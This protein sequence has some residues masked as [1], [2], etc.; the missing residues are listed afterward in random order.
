MY[1]SVD[2]PFS[3]TI[4]V[5]KYYL[6]NISTEALEQS[7]I[8]IVWNLRVPRIILGFVV[9]GS[10]A[11]SGVAMQSITRNVMADPFI[12][13]ISSGA[14]SFVSIGFLVGGNLVNTTWFIPLLAFLGALFALIIVIIIGG[15]SK[16]ASPVKLILAGSAVSITLNAIGQLGIYFSDSSNKSN[17]VVMWMMGSLASARWNNIIFT[18]ITSI[19]GIIFFTAFS[20]AFDLISLGD[21][22]A[23]SLGANVTKIKRISLVVVAIIAGVSVASCG[24]IGLVGFIIPHITRFLFGAGH[25]KQFPLAFFFGG[26]F[27]IWMDLLARTILSPVELPVGVFTSLC[28]GP[29]FIWML[30]RR[31]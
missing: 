9:G 5:L 31:K 12:L 21:E 17:S 14:L 25:R 10:L 28:G 22:T 26:I 2:V 8:Y 16:D 24:I 23:I 4:N 29:Y 19:L 27:L 15:F 3:E 1:G 11:I 7:N 30:R 13:G 18:V 6:L 20:R